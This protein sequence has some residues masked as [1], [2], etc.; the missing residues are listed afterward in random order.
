MATF[1]IINEFLHICRQSLNCSEVKRNWLKTWIWLKRSELSVD[2]SQ[3]IFVL[4]TVAI[5]G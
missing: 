3:L 4:L 5:T 1:D 2:F